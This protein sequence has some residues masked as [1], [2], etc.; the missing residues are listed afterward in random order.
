[1]KTNLDKLRN[2]AK[3]APHR[4]Y[5]L[6]LIALAVFIP[7]LAIFAYGPDRPTYTIADP[8]DH[9][10]FNSITDNP[11][12]GDE[13]N[14]VLVRDATSTSNNDWR[15]EATVQDG[16]E[17][18]VKMIVHNNAADHLNLVATNTRV[19]ADVPTTTS[20]SQTIQGAVMADNASPQ[21][22]WDHVVLKSDKRFNVALV[23]GSARYFNNINNT[24]GFPLTDSIASADGVQVGYETM[25]GNIPGCF[26]YSGF[27]YF[28]VK[29]YGEAQPNFEMSKQVR[30]HVEGQ[31]GNW[32]KTA[33][34][35]PSD[36]VDYL[37]SYKNTGQ[38]QQNNVVAKDFLPASIAYNN[39]STKY[40]NATNP[41]PT[42]KV[43]TDNLTNNV[44][45]NLGN[46]TPS[47]NA[48]V[49]FTGSV[50]AEKDLP[51]CGNNVL[52]NI[53]RIETDN[54]SKTDYADVSVNKKCEGQAS[55]SCD[56]LTATK[57]SQLQ[58]S[59][60]VKLSSTGAT[61]KEVSIDFGDGQTAVRDVKTLPVSHTY[62]KTGQYTVKVN[63]SFDVNGQTVKNVTSDACQ[64]AIS[65]E[66][67]VTPAGAITPGTPSTIP[68]T[69]PVEIFASILGVSALAL[70]IQQWIA[71][72][73]AVAALRA[74]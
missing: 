66:T 22:I 46:Y 10:T 48:L 43:A 57:I 12:W 30:K 21:K 1:M 56:A 60:N 47:S 71:S 64:V 31:T 26:K 45:I 55:Y 5:A 33:T 32:Q 25:N 17:Y 74:E 20:T 58:Y 14:S 72:R 42:G 3:Y 38:T 13:R 44:G 7:T 68:A 40:F 39:G 28:K 4:V 6:I 8:A 36:K 15:D 9:I 69:G 24:T 23:P 51:K 19:N 65:T 37:I 35:N 34:V 67:P 54:G 41:S 50:A 59:F 49:T 18:S 29:V 61:P 16:K 52:R 70:G 62:A 53:A 27:V 73:R 11:N 63:A 2:I